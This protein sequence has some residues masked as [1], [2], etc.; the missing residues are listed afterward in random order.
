M[1]FE[2]Y[3]LEEF[4]RDFGTDIACLEFILKQKYPKGCPCGNGKLYKISGRK[5]FACSKCG[6]HIYPLSKTVFERSRTPLRRWFYILYLI[7]NSPD[8]VSAKSIER[9][10]HV[11]YK[12]AW[13]MRARL[14][15]KDITIRKRKKK[16]LPDLDF[17]F[18]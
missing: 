13:R 10:L 2:N 18:N 3:T 8:I 1:N 15:G 11:S 7:S 17:I 9:T 14:Y 12:T 4:K 16:H 6:R 5:G